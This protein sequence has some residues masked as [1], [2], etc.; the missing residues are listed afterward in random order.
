MALFQVSELLEFT[1]IDT[2]VNPQ[3]ISIIPGHPQVIPWHSS[4]RFLERVEPFFNPEL[5]I[6]HIIQLYHIISPRISGL[7]H[8]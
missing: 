7:Y 8:L 5:I 2:P 4:P 1:Q 6:N 3:N